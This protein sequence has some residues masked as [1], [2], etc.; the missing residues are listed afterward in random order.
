VVV[1][2]LA[3]A[4]MPVVGS[5]PMTEQP[6]TIDLAGQY[7]AVAG[8]FAKPPELRVYDTGSGA[9]AYSLNHNF[10]PFALQADGK[11][12]LAHNAELGECR[13]EWF[14]PAEPVPHK[15]AVCPRG[16]VRMANDRI[17][18]DRMQGTSS[19]LDLVSLNGDTRSPTF[20]NPPGALTGFDW[21]GTKLA[22]GVQGC[23]GTDDTL[24]VEDLAGSEPPIVE[25]GACTAAIDTRTVRADRKGLIRVKVS[26]VD[27]CAGLLT[28]YS[29]RSVASRRSASFS[30]R[31][32][33]P[34]RS[35]PIRLGSLAEV[36]RRGSKS[37]TARVE[38]DQR[39]TNVRA[40][41]GTVRVLRPKS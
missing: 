36:R 25:G 7:V 37:Y 11:L 4:G 28:L 24:W 29:G 12:A 13:I 18:V 20:F 40:F 16:D 32:G 1:R 21:D 8:F 3:A 17:V 10:A 15:L 14:S 34:A 23:V 39:G 26:C 27:G 6:N 19:S 41:K 38:I 31:S 2:N 5:F 22:Y 30:I 9:V 35:V 33:G